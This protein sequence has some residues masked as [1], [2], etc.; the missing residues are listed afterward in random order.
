MEVKIWETDGLFQMHGLSDGFYSEDTTP[1]R[2]IPIPKPDTALESIRSLAW[3]FR[4]KSKT[5]L[6]C[7]QEVALSG[8]DIFPLQ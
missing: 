8:E 1:Q 7:K 4:G 5:F 6:F 2:I 3:H